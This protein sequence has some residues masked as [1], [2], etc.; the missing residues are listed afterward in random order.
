[1]A[2]ADQNTDSVLEFARDI[3]ETL[4]RN[5][6]KERKRHSARLT[7]SAGRRYKPGFLEKPG[8]SG[9]SRLAR[10][11]VP[12]QGGVE[13]G[14]GVTP[15]AIGRCT[16]DAEHFSGFFDRETGEVAQLNELGFRRVV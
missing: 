3:A 7:K 15:V 9:F 16:G 1:M 13:P 14:F 12:C 10:P 8:L 2:T 11:V 4:C 5:L 6:I